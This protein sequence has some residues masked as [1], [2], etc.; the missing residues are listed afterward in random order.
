MTTRFVK[1]RAL[2]HEKHQAI[3]ISISTSAPSIIVSALGFFAA[4]FGVALYSNIDMI[5]SMC[6]LMARGAIISML[7]VLF[8]LPALF[9]LLDKPIRKTTFLYGM[10]RGNRRKSPALMAGSEEFK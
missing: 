10:H 4:T 5:S 7:S 1:E 3:S 2:G 8:V 9:S 6:K